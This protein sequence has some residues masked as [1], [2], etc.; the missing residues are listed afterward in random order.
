MKRLL[1]KLLLIVAL[2]ALAL[3]AWSQEAEPTK[4]AAA[5]GETS[6]TGE[7]KRDKTKEHSLEIEAK[8]E[9][10]KKL[11]PA[12]E[13]KLERLEKKDLLYKSINF[14]I[15]FGLIIYF[16]AKPASEFFTARTASIRQGMSDAAA[17]RDA[18]DKRLAEIEQKM[19]HL[20]EEI[21]GL[22]AEAAKEDALQAD[23]MRQATEAEGAK[24][25]AAAEAEI[26][27][28][29]RTA[30]LELKAY[31]AKLAV[32]LA[33]ERIK[34]RMTSEAQGRLMQSFMNDIADVSSA[35][36]KN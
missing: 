30:R 10:G 9:E 4:P 27:V 19:S 32:D 21:A 36:G 17:A 28:K 12:E 6:A 25:L 20:K 5:T 8:A 7:T 11:T 22:R 29:T 33:E 1:G 26:D 31:A 2:A 18:A 16:L 24:I 13:E 15:L 14:V 3:P 34:S 35:G 23:R